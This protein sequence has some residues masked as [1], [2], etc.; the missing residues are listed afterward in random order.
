[1]RILVILIVAL[2]MSCGSEPPPAAAPAAP[3][4]IGQDIAVGSITWRVESVKDGGKE[5]S[6]NGH[7]ERTE[8]GF[9]IIDTKVANN[10]PATIKIVPP[11]LYTTTHVDIKYAPSTELTLLNEHSCGYSEIAPKETKPC[12]FIYELRPD[13]GTAAGLEVS[14]FQERDPQGIFIELVSKP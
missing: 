14:D 4:A 13:G 5:L 7:T 1:M 2:L 9:V 8:W 10:G 3:P 6:G 12:R 11:I